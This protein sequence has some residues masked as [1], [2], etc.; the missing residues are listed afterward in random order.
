MQEGMYFRY[1]LQYFQVNDFQPFEIKILFLHKYLDGNWLTMFSVT[2]RGQTKSANVTLDRYYFTSIEVNPSSRLPDS[3]LR[4]F[5][6]SIAWLAGF[7]YKGQPLS[8]SA[9]QW[10]GGYP[11]QPKESFVAPRGKEII[12]APAGTFNTTVVS[13]KLGQVRRIWVLV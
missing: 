5:P 11:E 2:D 8:L 3:Y 1:K 4:A 7:S 13:W 9:S 12:T 6:D 10:G